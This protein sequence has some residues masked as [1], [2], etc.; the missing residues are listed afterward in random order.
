MLKHP[1]SFF[2]LHPP[3]YKQH[4]PTNFIQ[5]GQHPLVMTRFQFAP[6]LPKISIYTQRNMKIC[7]HPR[8]SS[9]I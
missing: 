4:H 5:D 7:P 3:S 9:P 8:V 1:S 2:I 6:Y